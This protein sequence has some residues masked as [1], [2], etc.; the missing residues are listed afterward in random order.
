MTF[1]VAAYVILWIGLFVYLIALSAR[2]RALRDEAR[3]L[4]G[5]A[6][7]QPQPGKT[8]AHGPG[9]APGGE[10]AESARG[11]RNPSA[12]ALQPPPRR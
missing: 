6:R 5:D 9:S 7:P 10:Q 2:V 3:S 11:S 4:A 1:F 8:G 12:R